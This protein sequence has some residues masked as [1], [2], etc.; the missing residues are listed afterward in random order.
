MTHLFCYAECI[1]KR[2][3]IFMYIKKSVICG[4]IIFTGVLLLLVLSILYC[5]T[6]INIPGVLYILAWV[7]CI[8]FVVKSVSKIEGHV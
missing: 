8:F 2:G 7:L 4:V 1:A 6:E 5:F 3:V